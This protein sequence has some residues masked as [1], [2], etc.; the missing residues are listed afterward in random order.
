MT[1]ISL[2]SDANKSTV[3]LVYSDADNTVSTVLVTNNGKDDIAVNVVYRYAIYKSLELDITCKAG[4]IVKQDFL[5]PLDVIEEI[6]EKTKMKRLVVPSIL[7]FG[8]STG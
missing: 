7:S 2:Y 1:N 5:G 4:D 3:E 6:S 8:V